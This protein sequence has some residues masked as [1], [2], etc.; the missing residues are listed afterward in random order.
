MVVAMTEF[1]REFQ[2]ILPIG[3]SQ[4]VCD[5]G[6]VGLTLDSLSPWDS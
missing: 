5:R 3:F 6:K 1:K 4:L 2:I